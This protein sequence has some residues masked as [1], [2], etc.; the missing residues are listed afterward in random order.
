MNIKTTEL[1][2]DYTFSFFG[3]FTKNSLNYEK[4]LIVKRAQLFLDSNN[5]EAYLRMVNE[6]YQPTKK[7]KKLLNSHINELLFDNFSETNV[8][9]NFKK[10]EKYLEFGLKL[11]YE[12]I[13]Y[14]IRNT[15]TY[16]QFCFP[17]FLLYENAQLY[18]NVDETTREDFPLLSQETKDI[19]NQDNF[20]TF[21]G[22]LFK[23]KLTKPYKCIDNEYYEEFIN[24]FFTVISVKPELLFKNIS[25]EQF[26]KINKKLQQKKITRTKKRILNEVI[27]KLYKKDMD[28]LL[29][30]TKI[31]YTSERVVDITI[32]NIKNENYNMSDLPENAISIIKSIE[33]V[34]KKV[35][36]LY[37]KLLNENPYNNLEDVNQLDI[38]LEKRI[39]EVLSKYLTIDPS[40]RTSLMSIQGKNAEQLMIEALENIHKSFITVFE[41]L[42]QQ[43][44][45]SLSVTNR[46]TKELSK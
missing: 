20:S 18:V 27:D 28:N 9:L 44:V 23:E 3:L 31:S 21:L 1:I 36:Q 29:N 43:S 2:K 6:G 13:A 24:E 11:T 32:S 16:L 26:L 41:N 19:I 7:Q 30:E 46:Y 35:K 10:I 37:A 4:K 22:N 12:N 17:Y 34:Y 45:N 5:Y 15:N 8:Y 14:L 39:P 38:L 25:F 42:N 40:Y 33:E